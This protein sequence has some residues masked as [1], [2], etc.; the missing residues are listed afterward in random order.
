[1]MRQQCNVKYRKAFKYRS[2]IVKLTYRYHQLNEAAQF[3]VD[4]GYRILI[5]FILF[6]FLQSKH[7]L[8]GKNK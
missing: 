6:L 8:N 1:M 7:F 2:Y 5:Q 4:Y 3:F